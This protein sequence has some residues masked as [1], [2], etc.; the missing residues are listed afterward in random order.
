MAS[1]RVTKRTADASKPRARPYIL[2]D[3]DLHGFGLRVM[4]GGFESYVVEYRS[5]GGGRRVST[6]RLTLGA[7]TKLTPE[8]ARIPGNLGISGL[9]EKAPEFR[10]F[11]QGTCTHKPKIRHFR[12]FLRAHPPSVSGRDF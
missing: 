5:H 6:K 12:P 4:P 11:A 7:A 9:L 3:S 2:Y 8:Q 1:G 10:G